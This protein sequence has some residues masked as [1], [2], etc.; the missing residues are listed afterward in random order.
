MIRFVVG[1]VGQMTVRAEV[2][3]TDATHRGRLVFDR[4]TIKR[5]MDAT[6]DCEGCTAPCCRSFHPNRDKVE[7][8]ESVVAEAEK[9][10]G[11]PLI[12]VKTFAPVRGQ[13][14]VRMACS[15]LTEDARCGI[16]ERRPNA[17]REYDCRKDSMR[18]KP[19]AHKFGPGEG[20]HCAWPGP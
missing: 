12:L 17:C 2:I 15:A 10:W 9:Q 6:V 13:P 11:V 4:P 8:V 19:E 1:H 5:H 20:A 16:Y 7:S 14:V 3:G 18:Y